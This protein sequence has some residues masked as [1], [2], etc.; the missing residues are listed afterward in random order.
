[1]YFRE[2]RAQRKGLPEPPKENNDNNDDDDDV[3]MD[4]SVDEEA[5]ESKALPNGATV[6]SPVVT[7]SNGRTQSAETIAAVP[8]ITPT[9]PQAL[10][11]GGESAYYIS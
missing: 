7:Q 6:K 10:L 2:R 3:E 9:M 11:S 4:V 1:M 5:A 8:V